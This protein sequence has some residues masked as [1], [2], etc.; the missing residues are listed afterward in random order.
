MNDGAEALAAY[1][2][3][4]PSGTIR[5]MPQNENINGLQGWGANLVAVPWMLLTN[6]DVAEDTVYDLIRVIHTNQEA[7]GAGFGAFN[8]ADFNNKAPANAMPYHP[9]AIRYFE[10]VGM[11]MGN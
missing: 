2:A 3:V 6:A 9:G 11:P 8:G 10:E 1:T 7:L 4:L 5:A